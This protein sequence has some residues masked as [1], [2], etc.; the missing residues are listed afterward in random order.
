MP[1]KS[2]L[3]ISLIYILN[4]KAALCCV[5]TVISLIGA[6]AHISKRMFGQY[7][8]NFRQISGHHFQSALK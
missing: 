2:I 3:K 1:K 5:I 4:I 7:K 6:D 8:G